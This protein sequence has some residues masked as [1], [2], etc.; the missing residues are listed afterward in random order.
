MWMMAVLLLASAA[1]ACEERG[2]RTAATIPR[3]KFVAA[4]VALR[5]GDTT[6]AARTEALRKH[7]VTEAQLRAFVAAHVGDT[8]LAGAWD[9]I[10]RGVEAKRPEAEE[11]ASVAPVEPNPPA[12]PQVVQKLPRVMRPR[13]P[14]P[15]PVEEKDTAV[16]APPMPAPDSAP[17]P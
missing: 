16:A 8:L 5:I 13:A 4:N 12:A 11:S 6:Q 1:G 10:A 17:P 15:R 3:E 2:T 14:V 7:R 9:E